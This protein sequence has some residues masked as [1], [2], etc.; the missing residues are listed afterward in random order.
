M[1]EVYAA[2]TLAREQVTD[3]EREEEVFFFPLSPL[4][5]RASSSCSGNISSGYQS[6]GDCPDELHNDA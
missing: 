3:K 1:W 2:R 5:K 6:R 4:N